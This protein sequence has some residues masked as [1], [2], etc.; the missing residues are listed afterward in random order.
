[1]TLHVT[2]YERIGKW[3]MAN[4]SSLVQSVNELIVPAFANK[5]REKEWSDTNDK[6]IYSRGY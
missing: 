5:N 4:W 2:V 6:N 3:L 1:M